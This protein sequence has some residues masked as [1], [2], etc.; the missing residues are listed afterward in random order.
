MYSYLRTLYLCIYVN[1]HTL[2]ADVKLVVNA[3]SRWIAFVYYSLC[4]NL[5]S[6]L[7]QQVD[8]LLY[9]FLCIHWYKTLPYNFCFICL[10]STWEFSKIKSHMRS[11]TPRRTFICVSVH[12]IHT[13]TY[14]ILFNNSKRN[15]TKSQL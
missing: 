1:K 11:W 8:F 10:R 15:I 13:Y 5:F 7:K 2:C 9:R 6:L 4:D 14:N 3:Q 12:Y